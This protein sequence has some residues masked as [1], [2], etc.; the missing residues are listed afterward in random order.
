MNDTYLLRC[1]KLEMV[2]PMA[3]DLRIA[4]VD[5]LKSA[6]VILRAGSPVLAAARQARESRLPHTGRNLSLVNGFMFLLEASILSTRQKRSP[7]RYRPALAR[8][9]PEGSPS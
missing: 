8:G 5:Y 2:A 6:G 7:K 9:R 1:V 3:I 4:A